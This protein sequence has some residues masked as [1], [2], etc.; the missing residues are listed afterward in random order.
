MP[1]LPVIG[2]GVPLA[3]AVAGATYLAAGGRL[4]FDLTPVGPS[5][6]L[7]QPI[8]GPAPIAVDEPPTLPIL[9]AALILLVVCRH[10]GD[11]VRRLR[12]VR[13]KND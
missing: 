6:L 1:W 4:P 7:E 3:G 10:A 13:R 5:S 8:A 11:A 9:G 12:S 2:A